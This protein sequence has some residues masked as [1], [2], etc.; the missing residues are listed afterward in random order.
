M[1]KHIK[2]LWKM[3]LDLKQFSPET[4]FGAKS[5]SN[6]FS[7]GTTYKKHEIPN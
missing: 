2:L 1:V 7:F 6:G 4:L 5:E 3:L